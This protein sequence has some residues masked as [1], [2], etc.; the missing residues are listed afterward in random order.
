MSD[1]LPAQRYPIG[2]YQPPDTIDTDTRERWIATIESLP[3]QLREAVSNIPERELA[4]ASYRPGGWTIRQLLHHIADS[5]LNSYIRFKLGL[6]EDEPTVKPYDEAA[7][8]ELPD[9]KELPAELSLEL[10][11]L[12]HQRWAYLLR[13]MSEADFARAVIHPDHGRVM[14]LDFLLGLYDWHSRHHLQH[15]LNWRAQR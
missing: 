15:I 11:D 5:H 7:W 14:R 1:P 12:L 10:I 6:T 9:S 4:E 13:Q 3:A 2:R 8:A